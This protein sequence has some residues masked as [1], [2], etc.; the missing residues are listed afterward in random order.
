MLKRI[1]TLTRAAL[2]V[3]V[4]L[5]AVTAATADGDTIYVC[6]DGSGDYLTIQEGIDAAQDGDDVVVC[7]G[8]YTGP[9]NKN[10]DFGGKLITVR[11]ENG[12]ENCIIDCEDDGRGFYFHSG[13]TAESVM[14]GLTIGNGRVGDGAGIYCTNQSSPTI[15]NC[16]FTDNVAD[17]GGGAI[18]CWDF[19]SPTIT[20]CTIMGNIGSYYGG[21]AVYCERY[22]SP[23]I[24]NCTITTNTGKDGAAIHCWTSCSPSILD[25][26]ISGNTTTAMGNGGAIYCYESSPTLTDCVVSANRA[27]EGGGLYCE[28]QSGPTI[29]NCRFASNV[30]SSSSWDEGGGGI[31]CRSSSSPNITYCTIAQNA[32]RSGGGI[33]CCESSDPTIEHCTLSENSATR[34]G[35]GISCDDQNTSP[36]ISD[37]TITGNSADEISAIGGG[38]HC[39]RSARPTVTRCT[40]NE[41]SAYDGGGAHCKGAAM[42]SDCEFSGNFA[43]NRGGGMHCD[44]GPPPYPTLTNCTIRG[45]GCGQ[46]GGGIAITHS[47]GSGGA[48]VANCAIADNSANLGGGVYT[49]YGSANISNCIISGN[50]A[51]YDGAGIY[52]NYE[53][54]P[55]ISDC[56][57]VDNTAA[58]D[59][60][61][62]YCQST[63]MSGPQLVNCTFSANE[64]QSGGGV[65]C[66]FNS[67]AVL[68]NS[69]LWGDRLAGK[70]QGTEIVLDSRCVLVV[71]Y[72]DVA[73]GEAD[74]L[75]VDGST[76][77]WG[78]GNIDAD[79]LFVDPDNGDYRLSPGS[80][81]IDAADNEA[82]PAD[83]LDLDG[84]G[85]TEEPMP[86]DLDGNPRFID[87]P[88][89][90]D[91]G[92][93]DPDYPELPIVDM[94]AYEF[95][96]SGD[97]NGDGCVDH[98]D[99][100]IL[101]SDWGC[102]GGDCP[103]DCDFDGDTDQADLGILLAHWGQGCP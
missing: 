88:D 84:D 39:G 51:N 71:S 72:C 34:A 49:S 75:I 22:S 3:P 5:V 81:C 35:G 68:T 14:D 25:C 7:D 102:T 36:T 67:H 77:I 55:T 83:G 24:S 20:N 38:L 23:T 99:L 17:V 62:F 44:F 18:C 87:D 19:S 101:L 80:P 103:G 92:N 94:G 74:V 98:A 29:A 28:S 73:G 30:A 79:P 11:S 64:A 61:G 54:S 8:I 97:L 12:P 45:N 47:G 69:I 59:G 50:T 13:E 42:I 56:M 95:Q 57:I 53:D 43:L 93:P 78:S 32:A 90:E 60:G 63:G 46:R 76:L 33:L 4:V 48:T 40:F 1:Q 9:G 41:N 91:T 89:T 26:T 58:D 15:T 31:C 2:T 82:V 27:W 96:I 21:G 65:F 52:S 10:L 6:W 100:G 85:D 70:Q 16:A 66:N 86:F 37:C